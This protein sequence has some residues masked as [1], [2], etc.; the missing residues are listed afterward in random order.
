[1]KYFD[2]GFSQQYP[3]S[4]WLRTQWLRRHFLAQLPRPRVDTGS[5]EEKHG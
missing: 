1:M 4:Y 5:T 2:S 3:Y